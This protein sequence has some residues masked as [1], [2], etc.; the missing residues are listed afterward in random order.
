M[1]TTSYFASGTYYFAGPGDVNLTGTIFG[2]APG[3][4]TKQITGVEPVCDGRRMP[5]ARTPRTSRATSD[6]ASRSSSAATACSE[7]RTRPSVEL[8]SRVPG[9]AAGSTDFGASPG[10]TIWGQDGHDD[11][12]HPGLT[13]TTAFNTQDKNSPLVIH[14]LVYLP[15]SIA[16]IREPL[17]P[18]ADGAGSSWVA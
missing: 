13:N 10:V 18:G 17:N 2:G 9:T 4:E 12:L 7:R 15:D 6:P 5:R 16:Q 1:T 14:G 8:Y 11:Q 3:A